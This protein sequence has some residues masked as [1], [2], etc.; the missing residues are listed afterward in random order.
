MSE[1]FPTRTDD[2]VRR[3]FVEYK[4][5]KAIHDLVVVVPCNYEEEQIDEDLNDDDLE[6]IAKKLKVGTKNSFL[7]GVFDY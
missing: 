5:I 6:N 2:I 7:V 3:V 4:N 1:V